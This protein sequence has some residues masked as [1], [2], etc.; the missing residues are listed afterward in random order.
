MDTTTF[1]MHIKLKGQIS[2][3]LDD[4]D[5]ALREYKRTV[6][7]E[8]MMYKIADNVLEELPYIHK[9]VEQTNYTDGDSDDPPFAWFIG[10]YKM[11]HIILEA[12]GFPAVK[13]LP[14]YNTIM[15]E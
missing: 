5:E 4:I 9:M 14:Y 8:S 6:D 12:A 3:T 11:H 10:F 1:D 15:S 7:K 13:D 2:N